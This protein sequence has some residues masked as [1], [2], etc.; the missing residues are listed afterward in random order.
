MGNLFT[1]N[2]DNP[3]SA[4]AVLG[5]FCF[6]AGEPN[7]ELVSYRQAWT[8]TDFIIMT[9][10]E[11]GWND[12]IEQIYGDRAKKVTRFAIKKEPDVFD[13]DNLKKIVDGLPPE[14]ELRMI[15]EA[16]YDKC[17][18]ESWS[19]DLVSVYFDYGQYR[20]IGLGVVAMEGREIVSG[21]SSYSSF[22][23]GIEIEVDTRKDYRRRGLAAACSAKLILECV[24][25][26]WYPSWDAQNLW[27]VALAEKL[28]YHLDHEYV[29]YEVSVK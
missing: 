17:L 24:K 22:R 21:A 11:P 7:T 18:S 25:R 13:E 27:S 15:D 6:F 3:Q 20:E 5:D 9:A 2:P 23:G 10:R 8:K 1:N 19:R 12:M 16:L 4:M 29:A 28:G 14:F 26:G